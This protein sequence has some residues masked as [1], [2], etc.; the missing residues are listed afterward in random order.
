MPPTGLDLLGDL[1]GAPRPVPLNAMCSSRC[2]TPLTGRR[3]VP[4]A[5]APTQQPS[6]TV[7]TVV[8]G[9]GDDGQAV[10]QAAD[11]DV[12]GCSALMPPPPW[13]AIRARIWRLE[14]L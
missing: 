11:P 8:I 4:G 13:H 14:R 10:V 12:R 6:D 5:G 9:V 3:L 1:L 7:S 2:A